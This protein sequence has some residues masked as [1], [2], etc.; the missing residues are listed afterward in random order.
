MADYLSGHPLVKAVY[1][2]GLVEH[3]EHQ[4][5][6]DESLIRISAGIEESD[7]LLDDLARAFGDGISNN[8]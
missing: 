6:I 4:R 3:P 7:D 8:D 5:G 1:Y 2:P